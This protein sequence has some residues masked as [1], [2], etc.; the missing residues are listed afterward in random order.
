ML[1][2]LS[3]GASSGF[4]FFNATTFYLMDGTLSKTILDRCDPFL[5][6]GKISY[7]IVALSG[8]A[9]VI[10]CG[11][12]K[13]IG[14]YDLI[15]S[16][17]MAIFSY[18]YNKAA[19]SWNKISEIG[20]NYRYAAILFLLLIPTTAGGFTGK[21]GRLILA[22][23]I[24]FM[25]IGMFYTSHYYMYS[26]SKTHYDFHR[27]IRH[28]MRNDLLPIVFDPKSF[29]PKRISSQ[30]YFIHL[31]W[32]GTYPRY[33]YPYDNSIIYF[34]KNKPERSNYLFIDSTQLLSTAIGLTIDSNEQINFH[35][36]AM[37]GTAPTSISIGTSCTGRH[38]IIIYHET[39]ESIFNIG[40]EGKSHIPKRRETKLTIDAT[41]E[42][43]TVTFRVLPSK[44]DGRWSI[45]KIMLRQDKVCKFPR[46]YV[47]MGKTI[48]ERVERY[49]RYAIISTRDETHP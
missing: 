49:G 8:V 20:W 10:C 4:W 3:M 37:F 7:W 26:I 33:G 32:F 42:P 15:S 12:L 30:P 35:D 1:L 25:T 28:A 11:L 43:P 14:A 22:V 36:Q 21:T 29:D 47:T 40:K 16:P 31:F 6:N 9:V 19:I 44:E 41:G 24:A 2:H 27:M 5:H 48:F 23:I 38:E 34:S 18:V 45:E 17:D 13:H 39:S 46:S